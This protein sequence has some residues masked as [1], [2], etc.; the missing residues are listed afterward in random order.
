MDVLEAAYPDAHVELVHRDP[1]ELLV[2]VALS[3]QTTDVKVNQVTPALFARWPDAASLA[4]A[5]VAEVEDAIRTIGLYRNKA[6]NM[7]AAAQK[8]RA[9]HDGQVPRTREALEALPGVGQKTAG[10]ILTNAFGIPAFP[11]DTH[12]KRIA[13]LLGL[14]RQTDANKVEYDLRALYPEER[15]HLAHHVLIF[16]GRRTCIARR[17]ACDRCPVRDDCPSAR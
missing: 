15:W 13:R 3:A 17:P 7:V 2:A 10:V 1:F 5:Q 6:K 8:L 11:V 16:H 12:I 4:D 9:E 14:T